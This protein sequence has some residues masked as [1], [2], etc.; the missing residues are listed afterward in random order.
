V[1]VIEADIYI[2]EGNKPNRAP[3]LEIRFTREPTVEEI[4]QAK[5]WSATSQKIF[6]TIKSKDSITTQQLEQITGYK[7]STV[8][9]QVSI[10]R[11]LGLIET[12]IVSA[13]SQQ[14]LREI[15]HQTLEQFNK[16][17]E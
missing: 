5:K 14:D 2:T 13:D 3:N 17:S 4:S 8:R 10:L 7:P 9:A 6:E 15:M 16:P 1:I 11:R 12:H